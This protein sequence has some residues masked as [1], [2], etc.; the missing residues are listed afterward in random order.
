MR[1]LDFTAG[2]TEFES[3]SC[4]LASQFEQSN[5]IMNLLG[6]LDGETRARVKAILVANLQN[7]L[8]HN[9]LPSL[10]VTDRNRDLARDTARL[11][12]LILWHLSHK[13]K[14]VPVQKEYGIS[15]RTNW[16]EVWC[17]AINQTVKQLVAQAL[18]LNAQQLAEL[19]ALHQIDRA[20]KTET[21][22]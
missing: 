6:D 8:T 18:N 16:P 11:E 10:Q 7:I 2:Q 4:Y 15:Q 20:L 12:D 5:E 3:V 17:H 1:D 13:C 21:Q 22:N 19:R 14:S 9:G